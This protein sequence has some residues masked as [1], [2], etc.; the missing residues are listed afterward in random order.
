METSFAHTLK[1]FWNSKRFLMLAIFS[2]VAGNITLYTVGYLA[3]TRVAAGA[4][5]H[6]SKVFQAYLQALDREAAKADGTAGTSYWSALR[7]VRRQFPQNRVNIILQGS[8]ESEKEPRIFETLRNRP[9]GW[10]FTDEDDGWSR[11]FFVLPTKNTAALQVVSYV[12]DEL[13]EWQDTALTLGVYSFL[14]LFLFGWFWTRALDQPVGVAGAAAPEVRRRL[15]ALNDAVEQMGN[16]LAEMQAAVEAAEK[17]TREVQPGVIGALDEMA[18]QIRLLT[19]NGSIE[20]ARDAEAHRA[21]HV[22]LTEINRI[23]EH[24]RRL[25]R[26]LKGPEP[27][28]ERIRHALARAG[29]VIGALSSSPEK[30]SSSSE[31]RSA[32]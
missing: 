31:E 7:E 4:I 29:A 17:R 22:I 27:E 19:V 15:A 8:L 26:K 3:R 9:R 21:F 5:G 20:A 32:G 18:A 16:V 6:H 25:L 11:S 14:L 12:R 2:L 23:S 10:R 30:T 13:K 1:N 28:L 24:S